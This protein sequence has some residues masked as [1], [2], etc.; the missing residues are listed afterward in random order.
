MDGNHK[1][2]KYNIVIH[3]AIDGYSRLYTFLKASNN[4]FAST[5]LSLFIKASCEYGV[6]SRLRVDYGGENNDAAF[7]LSVLRGF[8]R[9]STIRGKSVHNVRIERSWVDVF[10]NVTHV[11]LTVFQYLESLGVLDITSSLDLW[12][13]HIICIP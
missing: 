3:G 5:V 7:A 10:Q 6:P 1:L 4:N 9:N 11:F 2:I 12:L 13:V 8:E